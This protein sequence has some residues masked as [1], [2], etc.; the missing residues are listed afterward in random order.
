LHFT[1]SFCFPL[2]RCPPTTGG[3]VADVWFKAPNETPEC[4]CSVFFFSIEVFFFFYPTLVG[5]FCTELLVPSP[6]PL[7]ILEDG[8]QRLSLPLPYFIVRHPSSFRF[9]VCIVGA[10]FFFP[11]C[12]PPNS[13]IFVG[14]CSLLPFLER[15]P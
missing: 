8:C 1:L 11:P 13:H 2:F 6:L 14:V 15:R 7:C 5:G 9:I 4:L 3:F 12:F 10:F